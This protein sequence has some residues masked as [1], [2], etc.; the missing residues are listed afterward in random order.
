MTTEMRNVIW[1]MMDAVD[2]NPETACASCP[3]ADRCQ[4][5]ELFWGCGVWEDQMGEDL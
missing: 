4:R 3:F 5:E 2:Y 1:N